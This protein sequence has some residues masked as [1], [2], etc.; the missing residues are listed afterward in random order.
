ML[1]LMSKRM[2]L[3][4]IDNIEN[5]EGT[6]LWKIVKTLRRNLQNTSAGLG[7]IFMT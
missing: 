4:T 5:V 1:S 3:A 2:L 7:S 6:I